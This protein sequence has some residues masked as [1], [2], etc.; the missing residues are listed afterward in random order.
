MV[1]LFGIVMSLAMPISYVASRA[2]LRASP[3][4]Q[5]GYSPHCHHERRRHCCYPGRFRHRRRVVKPGVYALT[6]LLSAVPRRHRRY[7]QLLLRAVVPDQMDVRKPS[8]HRQSAHYA[9]F[10][11]GCRIS[12]SPVSRPASRSSC[13]SSS[14]A[15]N[16]P[17]LCTTPE[18]CVYSCGS[19]MPA[20]YMS[21]IAR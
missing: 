21:T 13:Q 14:A 20:M 9:A 6:N 1:S 2:R 4:E 10:A 16:W 11:G 5:R 8:T 3:D 15:T 7:Y 12:H 17:T 19:L 18:V